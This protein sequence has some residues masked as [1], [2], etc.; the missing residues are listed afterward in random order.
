M[1]QLWEEKLWQHEMLG[2]HGCLLSF[3]R[4]NLLCKLGSMRDGIVTATL[5]NPEGQSTAMVIK[6]IM[7]MARDSEVEQITLQWDVSVPVPSK[8]FILGACDNFFGLTDFVVDSTSLVIPVHEDARST[9]SP[10]RI[11]EMFAGGIAG[12]RAAFRLVENLSP[13]H[14]QV[15]AIDSD[16]TAVKAYS[17]AHDSVIIDG[18]HRIPSDHFVKCSGDHI[19]H[20]D[21]SDDHWLEAIATWHPDICVISSPCPPWSNLSTGP[22]LDCKEGML[23]SEAL[24]K[25]K[26]L[27]PSCI[28]LEQVGGFAQHPHQHMILRQLRWSGY[29]LKWSRTIDLNTICPVSRPRWLGL[30]FRMCDETMQFDQFQFWGT[31]Q[32]ATPR[33]F[34]AVLSKPYSDHPSLRIPEEAKQLASEPKLLPPAKRKIRS[35]Q[36]VFLSRCT[37]PDQTVPCFKAFVRK[38]RAD[39]SFL[40]GPNWI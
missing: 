5:L 18:F 8:A 24:V 10:M 34:D 27:R 3:D 12:W 40:L 9:T 28:L 1:S 17:L 14:S 4:S 32:H 39:G 29:A 13:W 26:Y 23:M 35:P 15:V 2:S 33:S 7:V 19:I 30:A 31:Q 37:T 11:F 6:D 38:Q 22:G 21:V 16:L 20:G 36:E 25:I